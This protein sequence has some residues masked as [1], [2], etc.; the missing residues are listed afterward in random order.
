YLET[1]PDP[2]SSDYNVEQ[3]R[4][5]GDHH[6]QQ[7]R[8]STSTGPP[9]QKSEEGLDYSIGH[10][11]TRAAAEV[12]ADRLSSRIVT[13][14]EVL[15]LKPVTTLKWWPRSSWPTLLPAREERKWLSDG[16]K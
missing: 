3:R 9:E 14:T 7:G 6:H 11:G 12:P 10:G 5:A 2:E 1:R 4:A 13:E 15:R 8:A 16:R